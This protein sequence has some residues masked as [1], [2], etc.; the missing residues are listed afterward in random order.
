VNPNLIKLRKL[1]N[2]FQPLAE[3]ES[4]G[5][6]HID[7]VREGSISDASSSRGRRMRDP[8]SLTPEILAML[9]RHE[10]D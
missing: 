2:I 4:Q 1:P 7:K 6:I 5:S 3:D 9:D 10:P 8:I